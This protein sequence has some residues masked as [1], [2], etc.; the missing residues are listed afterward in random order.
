MF[1]KAAEMA[2]R[3]SIPLQNLWYLYYYDEKDVPGG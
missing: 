2:P 3:N 1:E